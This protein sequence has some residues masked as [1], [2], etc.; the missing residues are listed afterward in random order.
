MHKNTNN[1]PFVERLE[2]TLM[3]LRQ[4]TADG[5]E[6]WSELIDRIETVLSEEREGAS[7]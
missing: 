7:L 3:V 6:D 1:L 2:M 5:V 4:E